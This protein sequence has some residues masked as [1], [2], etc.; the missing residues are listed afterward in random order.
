LRRKFPRVVEGYTVAAACLTR[1]GRENEADAM[2]EQAARRF[3]REF[4]IIV[5]RARNAVR[6]K[7]WPN[8]FH[9]WE[10]IRN[11]FDHFLGPVGMAQSLREMGRH[12]EAKELAMAASDQFPTV[13]WTYAELANIAAAEGDF[14]ETRQ[15]WETARSRCPDFVMAYTAGAE[16]ARQVGQE[17]EA[18]KIL[19]LAV[20]RLRFN[21][22]LHL[23]YV[24]NAHHRGDWDAATERWALVSDRFPECTEARE[25]DAEAR[26]ARKKQDRV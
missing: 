6:R 23:E 3:P 21:L 4:E 10:S 20:M 25:R 18:D 15:H 17:A 22:D 19:G 13:P 1:L 7:D 2:I 24:R 12:A 26:A 9:R 16:A 5:A 14:N 11:Q 8:A